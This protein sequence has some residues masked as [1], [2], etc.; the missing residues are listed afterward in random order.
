M[1][2]ESQTRSRLVAVP[3]RPGCST[4]SQQKQV[5]QT[6]VHEAQ[7]R[8]RLA[9][10][11]QC[12]C[13]VLRSSRSGRSLVSISRPIRFAARS[14]PFCADCWRNAL[15]GCKIEAFQHLASQFRSRFQEEDVLQFGQVDVKSAG[16][17]RP[18]AHRD[19]K[20]GPAGLHATDG[21]QEK[22][23]AP[24]AVERIGKILSQENPVLD[25]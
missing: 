3:F 17:A 1:K 15:A 12:G 10:T 25:A 20:A 8:Q 24:L 7:E 14:N 18:G 23:L 9:T 2:Q 13:S 16:R 5:G 11:L 19:A 22:V 4:V 6:I 21:E